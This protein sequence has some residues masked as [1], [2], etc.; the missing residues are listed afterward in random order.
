VI[1]GKMEIYE[2]NYLYQKMPKVLEYVRK[3]EEVARAAEEVMEVRKGIAYPEGCPW[4]H[5]VKALS[6]L[7]SKSDG[8]GGSEDG[9]Y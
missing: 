7:P 6:A 8:G 1:D 2:W 3:L 9:I 5:L 4:D